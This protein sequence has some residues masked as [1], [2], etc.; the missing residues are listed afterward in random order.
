[1]NLSSTTNM[2]HELGYRL[3]NTKKDKFLQ[4]NFSFKKDI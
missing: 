3:L 4:N 1:M 2:V